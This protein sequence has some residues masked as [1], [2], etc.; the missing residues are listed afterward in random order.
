MCEIK[1][2]VK[3]RHN[4]VLALGILRSKPFST[5]TSFSLVFHLRFL[6]FEVLLLSEVFYLLQQSIFLLFSPSQTL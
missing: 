3:V 6:L 1:G 4:T 2:E 5:V